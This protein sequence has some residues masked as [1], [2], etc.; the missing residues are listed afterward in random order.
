MVEGAGDVE[1]IH[2][3]LEDVLELYGAIIGRTAAQ[4]ADHLRDRAAL[5]GALGRPADARS[6]RGR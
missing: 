1:F 4:A 2:L 6:L 3:E 5:E